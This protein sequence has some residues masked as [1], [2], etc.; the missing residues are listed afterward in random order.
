[1]SLRRVQVEERLNVTSCVVLSR[2]PSTVL[3]ELN[4]VSIS[5][6]IRLSVGL[7][8]DGFCSVFVRAKMFGMADHHSS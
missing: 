6:I 1:M 8:L 2:I 3:C 4:T 5:Y 7:L